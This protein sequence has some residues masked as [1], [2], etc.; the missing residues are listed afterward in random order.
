MCILLSWLFGSDNETEED[1]EL[2][3][4]EEEEGECDD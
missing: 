1:E 4:Y 2:M 3:M